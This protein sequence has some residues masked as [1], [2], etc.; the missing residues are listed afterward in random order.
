MARRPYPIREP[1]PRRATRTALGWDPR[2]TSSSRLTSLRPPP[3]RVLHASRRRGARGSG[4]F[5]AQRGRRGRPGRRPQ[6]RP[7][8]SLRRGD[9]SACG[10]STPWETSKLISGRGVSAASV[11]RNRGLRHEVRRPIAP[12]RFQ[13]EHEP[14][15]GPDAAGPGP[16]GVGADTG[17]RVS[18]RARSLGEAL[19]SQAG[20]GAPTPG[21][22]SNGSSRGQRT[23]LALTPAATPTIAAARPLLPPWSLP[24]RP[25]PW[26][27]P[28]PG[29]PAASLPA[30]SLPE[31]SL[32]EPPT[33]PATDAGPAHRHTGG[34][35]SRRIG[36]SCWPSAQSSRW[37]C[38]TTARAPWGSFR[39]SAIVWCA[40]AAAGWVP[41][42]NSPSFCPVTSCATRGFPQPLSC[43]ASITCCVARGKGLFRGQSIVRCRQHGLGRPSHRDDAS[44]RTPPPPAELVGPR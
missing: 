3:A 6:G 32:P 24:P 7:D 20:V 26:P 38:R 1:A 25:P 11:A 4:R 8:H 43:L 28:P 35:E 10:A 12:G 13:P 14:P 42:I 40:A 21:A 15:I 9:A 17:R 16:A 37:P 31:A 36:R 5:V 29:P 18:A 44:D 39:Y 27:P 30:T 41:F 23:L 22:K 2:P 19:E 34:S 33:R